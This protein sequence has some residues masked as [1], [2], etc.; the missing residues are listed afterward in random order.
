MFIRT[1]SSLSLAFK[2]ML[3]NSFRVFLQSLRQHPAP[4]HRLT[5]Y[6]HLFQKLTRHDILI[7]NA[8]VLSRSPH[9][10]VFCFRAIFRTPCVV[11]YH[12]LCRVVCQSCY[13]AVPKWRDFVIFTKQILSSVEVLQHF[14]LWRCLDLS[15][16]ILQCTTFG[17]FPHIQNLYVQTSL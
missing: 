7:Q 4:F 1:I 5:L 17:S 2:D 13:T 16:V 3:T 11:L 12:F 8:V 10:L 9:T 15:R 6:H 14:C